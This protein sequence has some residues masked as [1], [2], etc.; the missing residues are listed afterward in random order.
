MISMASIMRICQQ[1]KTGTVLR[2]CRVKSIEEATE[3]KRRFPNISMEIVET[4]D[5]GTCIILSPGKITRKQVDTL[6]K[7]SKLIPSGKSG[8]VAL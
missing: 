4:D 2:N 3:A 6:T 7:A 8:V 5:F 1:T